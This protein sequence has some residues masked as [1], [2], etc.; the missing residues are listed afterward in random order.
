[1]F[2]KIITYGK[3]IL[4]PIVEALFLS[5]KLNK[6]GPELSEAMEVPPENVERRR[7]DDLLLIIF[8]FNFCKY[9]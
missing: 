8:F 1:M 2:K 9:V 4:V 3:G 5:T 7:P 6:K